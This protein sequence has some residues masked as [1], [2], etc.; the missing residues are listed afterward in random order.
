MSFEEII[1]NLDETTIL[2]KGLVLDLYSKFGAQPSTEAEDESPAPTVFGWRERI[3]TCPAETQLS[4]AEFGEVANRKRSWAYAQVKDRSAAP[5]HFDEVGRPYFIA[6]EVR[7]WLRS[8]G[9]SVVQE[10]SDD[11]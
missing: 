3:W 5:V 2:T 1:G 4:V 9:D 6:Q 11:R 8:R 7:D 10:R